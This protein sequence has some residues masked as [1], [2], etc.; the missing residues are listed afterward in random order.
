MAVA[1]RQPRGAVAGNNGCEDGVVN[2][3][4]GAVAAVLVARAIPRR[5][6]LG[7]GAGSGQVGQVERLTGEVRQEEFDSQAVLGRFRHVSND[8]I[9]QDDGAKPAFV[10]GRVSDDAVV[11]GGRLAGHYEWCDLGCAAFTDD[12]GHS[13]PC[14][15][16]GK[17]LTGR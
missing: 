6:V 16:T 10:V 7:V 13:R 14:V 1:Q 4:W 9:N 2:F 3:G 15:I 5:A 11:V 8:C 17:S 12:L